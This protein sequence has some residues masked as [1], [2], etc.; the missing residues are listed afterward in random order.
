VRKVESKI[1]IGRLELNITQSSCG[2]NVYTVE[3]FNKTGESLYKQIEEFLDD[4]VKIT[5]EKIPTK[6]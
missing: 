6:I 4:D 3:L 1:L 2:E 5:I